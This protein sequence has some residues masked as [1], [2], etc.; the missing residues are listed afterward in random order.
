MSAFEPLARIASTA[1]PYWL[2]VAA[3][4]SL[5][6]ALTAKRVDQ[7]FAFAV[8]AQFGTTCTFIF[9]VLGLYVQLSGD[10]MSFAQL[11]PSSFI[12]AMTLSAALLAIRPQRKAELGMQILGFGLGTVVFGFFL[13]FVLSIFPMLIALQWHLLK[14]L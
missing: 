7:P 5:L 13:A 3:L 6:A 9:V 4:L 12:V 10:R 8:A 11:L 14:R 1:F 2:I